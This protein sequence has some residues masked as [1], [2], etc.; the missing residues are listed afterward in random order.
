[1]RVTI[2][3]ISVIL[4]WATTPLAIKWSAE[5]PGFVF[6]ITARMLLG[7]FCMLLFLTLRRQKLPEHSKAKRT[8]F[9]IAVQLYG[10]M[11]LV[12]WGAQFIPSGWVSLVFGLSPFL[13]AIFA[14]LWIQEKSLTL[15]K[16]I[17]YL[18]GVLGLGVMFSSAI[19]LNQN[20]V[21]GIIS[22]LLA[23]S[24]QTASSVWVK[25]IDAQLPANTQ[26][27][28]GL[29]FALPAFLATWILQGDTL[30]PE[31]LSIVN[32]IT[33]LYLGLVATTIGFILYYYVL[34]HLPATS[35]GMIPMISP[36]I[37]LTLGT[38]INHEPFTLKVAI[39]STLILSALLIHQFFDFFVNKFRP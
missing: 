28:G 11:T 35:V 31:H 27:A 30:F 7:T 21:L 8:Y 39:G 38:L 13:T 19:Q 12:Y 10:T 23:V 15:G 2:A 1:M 6:A 24:I 4:L 16:I 36:V 29:L 5:G 34:I 20:A 14:A 22:V 33:I 9:V 17:S 25:R 37:A 26:V 3:Y 32:S 18:L